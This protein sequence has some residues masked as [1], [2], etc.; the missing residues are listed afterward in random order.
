MTRTDT[1]PAAAP[2]APPAGKLTYEQ[3]L[4]WCD[5]D[6]WAEW[7][8]GEVILLMP[9]STRHQRLVGFLSFVLRAFLAVHRLG[10]VL[11]APFQMKLG[12]RLSGREPDLLVIRREHLDRLLPSR[13]D[14][15]ADLVIEVISPDSVRRDRQDKRRE[16]EAAGVAEYWLLDPDRHQADFLSLGSDGRY[17][18]LPVDEAGV[19]RSVA[20][21]RLWLKVAWLW[22]EPLPDLEAVQALGLLGPVGNDSR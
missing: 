22:Q 14:G 11:T 20:L 18:P 1:P 19:V 12:P 15:P 13:L 3:F 7:V 17:H 5:E 8:D 16:Y 6:T 2:P 4:E 21:P 9:P 10:E